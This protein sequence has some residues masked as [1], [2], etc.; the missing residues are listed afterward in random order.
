MPRHQ[1][2]LWYTKRT[3]PRANAIVGQ[4]I[5]MTVPWLTNW[6]HDLLSNLPIKW[7]TGPLT[8]ALINHLKHSG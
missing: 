4:L 8:D 5:H 3:G 7:L 6:L 1:H 2:K